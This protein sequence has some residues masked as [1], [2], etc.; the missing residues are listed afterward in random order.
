MYF[1][2]WLIGRLR[3]TN[4]SKGRLISISFT[5]HECLN[6]KRPIVYIRVSS[7]NLW[8]T[9]NII[10]NLLDKL[11]QSNKK[12]IVFSKHSNSSDKSVLMILFENFL[13]LYENKDLFVR[14]RSQKYLFLNLV[15]LKV[16]LFFVYLAY[17]C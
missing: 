12:I 17:F 4:H 11:Y 6:T 7:Y 16:C 15:Q 2:Y 13:K 1:N 10:C 9:R 3:R 5:A 14:N 8:I